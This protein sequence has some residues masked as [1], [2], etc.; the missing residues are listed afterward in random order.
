MFPWLCFN[1]SS[2]LFPSASHL[3]V[4]FASLLLRVHLRLSAAL[5]MSL[6]PSISVS[7]SLLMLISFLGHVSIALPLSF[8]S[9][10]F[11]LISSH[12]FAFTSVFYHVFNCCFLL[13]FHPSLFFLSFVLGFSSQNPL[14]FG[15][16]YI[17]TV[18]LPLVFSLY[19]SFMSLALSEC[20]C[21][22]LCSD[23]VFYCHSVMN[24]QKRLQRQL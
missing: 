2:I 17:L 22:T 13:H 15:L 6:H 24:Y 14:G 20:L 12:G 7:R 21:L 18:T 19:V 16:L 5:L 8:S 11:L 10:P 4:F 3:R 1:L 23:H 9:T